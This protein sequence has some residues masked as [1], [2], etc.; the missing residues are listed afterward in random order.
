M[1]KL[2]LTTL[3]ALPALAH[4]HGHADLSG[5]M[6]DA[7]IAVAFPAPLRAATLT[8]MRDHLASI[9]R[10]TAYLA[11]REFDQAAEVAE[12]RLGMSSM[13]LHNAHEAAQYMPPAMRELGHSLH[14]RASEFALKAKDAGAT[15]E[16]GPALVALAR[17]QE[18]CVA[19]HTAFRFK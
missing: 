19:C 11:T 18:S 10:I 8:H 5:V 12:S 13:A 15:G 14:A 4:A 7:R 3:A 1:K 9:G 2:L 6:P 17:V 16:L